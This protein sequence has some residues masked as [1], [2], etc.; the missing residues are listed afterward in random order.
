M[1]PIPGGQARGFAALRS[2]SAALLGFY[3][4]LD[5]AIE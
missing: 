4:D 5:I 1:K 3:R 2:L